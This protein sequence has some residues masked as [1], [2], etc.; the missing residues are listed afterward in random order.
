[1]FKLKLIDKPKMMKLKCNFTFP[2]IVLA[3]L[4][5]KEATPSEEIQ[6]IVADVP[7]DGLSKVILDK[8]PGEYIVP[9]S[10]INIV[11]NGTYDITKKAK[12]NVQIPEPSG[13]IEITTNGTYNIKD[14]ATAKVEVVSEYNA[15]CATDGGLALTNLAY[16]ITEL[17]LIDGS[18]I[19]NLAS[20]GNSR[21]SY[22][23]KWNGLKEI[24]KAYDKDDSENYYNYNFDINFASQLEHDSLI[25][26]IDNL[27]DIKTASIKPQKF[28]LG[29]INK[30][31]LTEEEIAVATSKG[32]NVS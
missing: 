16:L 15:K 32:W 29:N 1:M 18:K 14:K 2:N 6:E 12:A 7:Y 27:Y 3:N 23:K 9:E 22:L 24:G 30:K 5:E 28:I 31:K 21:V 13:I 10:E 19:F 4:Q 17:P 20:F 8:I 25:N 11:E 26:I